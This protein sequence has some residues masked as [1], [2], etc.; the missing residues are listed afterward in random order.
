MRD[1]DLQGG[2]QGIWTLHCSC[3]LVRSCVYPCTC[4]SLSAYVFTRACLCLCVCVCIR[5]CSAGIR[6][7]RERT[8]RGV[9]AAI[10]ARRQNQKKTD[11]LLLLRKNMR[12]RG[13]M[14]DKWNCRSID[15]I[16]SHVLQET[17]KFP[18]ILHVYIYVC[19][20][21]DILR[22]TGA[23]VSFRVKFPVVC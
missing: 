16:R 9:N 12:I 3:C 23:I 1:S 11:C 18:V 5:V 15:S 17:K 2:F 13:R 7:K 20:Y 14:R 10:E 19:I 6:S 8:N 4:L 21:K 22:I